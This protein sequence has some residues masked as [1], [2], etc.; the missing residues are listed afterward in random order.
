V[1]RHWHSARGLR[2]LRRDDRIYVGANALATEDTI[3]YTNR[4][5]TSIGNMVDGR[6]YYVINVGDGWIKL[7]E[8]AA[9]ALRASYGELYHPGNVVNLLDLSDAPVDAN[10]DSLATANNQKTFNAT[11]FSLGGDI[12][13][14]ADT[15]RLKRTGTVFNTFEL[16]QAVTYVKRAPAT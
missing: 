1:G 6:E 16:G 12:D 11:E 5:G 3:T 14:A 7:S 4:R 15:I 2:R 9:Q 8:S 13:S 10:G